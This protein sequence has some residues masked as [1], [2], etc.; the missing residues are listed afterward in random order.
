MQLLMVTEQQ[1]SD[2]FLNTVLMEAHLLWVRAMEW[3]L[4][5]F[6]FNILIYLSDHSFIH[7]SIHSS[8]IGFPQTRYTAVDGG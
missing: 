6:V 8:D 5:F 3:M 4:L 2:R 7:S 1:L